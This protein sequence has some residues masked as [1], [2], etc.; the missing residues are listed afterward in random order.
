MFKNEFREHLSK[1][2]T[3]PFLFIGSGFSRRYMETDTWKDLLQNMTSQL[4]LSKPFNFYKSKA[5]S[6]LPEVASLIGKEFNQIWWEEDDFIQ[7]KKDFSEETIN[8]YSPF[9]YEISK[10]IK[11]QKNILQNDELKQELNLLKKVNIDG[12]ITTNWDTLC[13]ELFPSYSTFIGQEELLFSELFNVGEIYKIHGCVTKPNS[14]ILTEEDYKEFGDRNPYLAAKLLTQFVE[15]PIIFIGYN[16]GDKNI[17]EILKSVV[18]CLTKDNIRKLQDRLIFCQWSREEIQT[19]MTDSVIT[20]AGSAIPIKLIKISSYID[21]YTVMANNK[22]KFPVKI[23]RQMKGMVYDFVKSNK[24]KEKIYIADNLEN[25][26]NTHNAEFVYGLGIKDKLAERGIKGLELKD[27]LLDIIDDNKW[28]PKS[29]AKYSLPSLQ[30]G[31]RFIPYFK[32]L[33]KGGFLNDNGEIDENSE[34]QEFTPNFIEAVNKIDKS[35]FYPA[36]S[37]SNKKDEI[38]ENCNSISDVLDNY[39]KLLHHILFIPLLET[40]K[41]DLESLKDFLSKNKELIQDSKNG[42]HFR[43]LICLYDYLRNKIRSTTDN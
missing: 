35:D 17:Q 33:K 1:F 5:N 43:K 2:E 31:A 15:N 28:E 41:I 19:Q 10:Y 12:I 25:L 4:K 30:I 13:E 26:E 38:N 21:L 11:E 37:Y 39:D 23:L 8:V 18:K 22:R 16:L 34:I 32:H 20:I 7:S 27:I 36:R 14:L 24:S 29:I 42:T 9:K 40:E 3:S 6:S